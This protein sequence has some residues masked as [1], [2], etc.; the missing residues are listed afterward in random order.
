MGHWKAKLSDDE[1]TD[2][3][4]FDG[5]DTRT[6]ADIEAELERIAQLQAHLSSV[7]S[8]LQLKL[9]QK[10][11]SPGTTGS[12][13]VCCHLA[14]ARWRWASSSSP[15]DRH[16]LEHLC[17]WQFPSLRSPTPIPQASP[18]GAQPTVSEYGPTCWHRPML[19][20]RSCVQRG[21]EARVRVPGP[22]FRVACHAAEAKSCLF[23]LLVLAACSCC[24]FLQRTTSR[25][26][27]RA[28]WLRSLYNLFGLG[29][30]QEAASILAVV[31]AATPVGHT[32][33]KRAGTR[34]LQ[35][36]G[37]IEHE[38]LAL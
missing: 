37:S 29:K 18:R 9:Q 32:H 20:T 27:P 13:E 22:G 8:A 11:Q 6:V 24:L 28:G 3:T 2:A 31:N 14:A 36:R 19:I 12:A 7:S 26:K 16:S 10:V 17:L 33:A 1:M 15:F 23:L 35:A 38:D 25:N 30:R 21:I 5:P 4:L 34:L